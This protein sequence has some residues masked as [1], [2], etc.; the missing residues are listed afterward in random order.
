M[1]KIAIQWTTDQLSVWG[2]HALVSKPIATHDQV[3]RGA[4]GTHIP[5]AVI[6]TLDEPLWLRNVRLDISGRLPSKADRRCLI[7]VVANRMTWGALG[8]L[9]KPMACNLFP[10]HFRAWPSRESE[11][12]QLLKWKLKTRQVFDAVERECY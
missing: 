1:F 8:V 2:I 6:L 5:L 4:C 3:V 12:P 10:C 11:V 7:A 9:M